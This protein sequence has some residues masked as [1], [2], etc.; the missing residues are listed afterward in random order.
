MKDRY[1]SLNKRINDIRNNHILSMI[2]KPNASSHTYTYNNPNIAPDMLK[3]DRQYDSINLSNTTA[4]SRQTNT[5]MQVLLYVYEGSGYEYSLS[6]QGERLAYFEHPRTGALHKHEFVEIMYVISGS[7]S[8][9]IAG[10]LHTFKSGTFVITDQNCR[11]SDYISDQNSSVIYIQVKADF[12]D[13]MLN[14]SNQTNQLQNFLFHALGK[15]KKEESILELLPN[16]S[17]SKEE[18][19]YLRSEIDF[20][21]EL[22]LQEDLLQK[23]HFITL[24]YGLLNRLLSIMCTYFTPTRHSASPEEK[25]QLILYEIERYIRSNY[26]HVTVSEL[27]D[28]FHYSRNYYANLLRKYRDTTF[29]EYVQNVRLTEAVNLLSSTGLSVKKIALECG[30][31]NTSFFYHLFKKKYGISPTEYRANIIKIM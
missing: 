6:H 16:K 30:Y 25:E 27:E 26:Q 22:L 4:E 23:E 21:M 10:E 5:N 9:Y 28:V 7:F 18:R 17:L 1:I 29:L 2:D 12:M 13:I 20:T 14:H 11:H 24:E 8:Q 15:Q 19:K 3:K 31:E